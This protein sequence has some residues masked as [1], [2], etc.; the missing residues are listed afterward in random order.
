MYNHVIPS[1][2]LEARITLD[3]GSKRSYISHHIR[4]AL[5]LTPEGEQYTSIATFGSCNKTQQVCEIVRIGMWLKD[6]QDRLLKMLIVPL[7][8]CHIK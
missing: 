8:H 5:S 4:D 7:S 2:L 6:G 1:E 3:T